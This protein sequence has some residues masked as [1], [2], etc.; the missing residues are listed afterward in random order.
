M[1]NL[2]TSIVLAVFLLTG[3]GQ[4]RAETD[5]CRSQLAL[6]LSILVQMYNDGIISWEAYETLA[7]LQV[8]NW[9]TCDLASQ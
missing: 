3:N 8:I 7:V 4:A 5:L 9:Q 1:R 6:N 2:I